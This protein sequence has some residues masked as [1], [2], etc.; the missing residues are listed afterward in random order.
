[1]TDSSWWATISTAELLR[2]RR[3][4]LE[5][6]TAAFG[7]T[8]KAEVE[9]VVQHAFVVLFRNREGVKADADGLYWYLKTVSRHAALDRIRAA[10][11][12]RAHLP[13]LISERRRRAAGRGAHGSPSDWSAEESE[14]ILQVFCALNELDRLVVWSYAVDG[15]SIRAIAR[16][17]DLNWHRVARIIEEALR[18]VRGKLAT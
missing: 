12:R 10:R 8:L 17:L 2:L 7:R 9:D 13:R 5:H 6:V 11:R 16:D 4:L 18:K 15:K 14:K 1:M 3:R